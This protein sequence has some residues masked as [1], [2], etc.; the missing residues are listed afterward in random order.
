MT[1]NHCYSL[2]LTWFGPTVYTILP[3]QWDTNMYTSPAQLCQVEQRRG[4]CLR[5]TVVSVYDIST[6]E[7]AYDVCFVQRE[8]KYLENN[9][10]AFMQS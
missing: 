4:Q 6:L 9:L 5:S 1:L 8:C 10:F 2:T 7:K 3:H